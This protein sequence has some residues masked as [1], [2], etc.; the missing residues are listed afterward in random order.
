MHSDTMI[1]RYD[2]PVFTNPPEFHSNYFFE[3][4]PSVWLRQHLRSQNS[5]ILF[6]LQ[7]LLYVCFIKLSFAFLKKKKR[8]PNKEIS[9]SSSY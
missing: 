9:E 2:L 4:Q 1:F 6:L 3:N 7:L 8:I 5:F